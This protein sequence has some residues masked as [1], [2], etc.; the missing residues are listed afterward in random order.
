[1]MW[2]VYSRTLLN[3]LCVVKKHLRVELFDICE[4]SERLIRVKND[5]EIDCL[6]ACC[7]AAQN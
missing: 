1:M 2:D 6:A 7:T 4:I 3:R 5:A